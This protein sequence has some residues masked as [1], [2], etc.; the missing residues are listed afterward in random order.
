MA[1][2]KTSYDDA[3]KELEQILQ[4]LENDKELSMDSIA[5]KVK[6]AAALIDICKKHLHGI[7]Q[8]LEK[9]ISELE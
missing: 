5:E 2:K 9:I 6:R 3:R 8:E 4:E 7:D 1:I